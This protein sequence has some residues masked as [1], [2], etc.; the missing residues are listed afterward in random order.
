[1]QKPPPDEYDDT[2]P[3]EAGSE[4]HGEYD[5]QGEL[6]ALAARLKKTNA[7]FRRIEE[8]VEAILSQ[9]SDLSIEIRNVYDPTDGWELKDH[10][11]FLYECYHS[12]VTKFALSKIANVE[13]TTIEEVQSIAEQALSDLGDFEDENPPVHHRLGKGG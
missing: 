3:E 13:A 5:W 10:L 2:R 8:R 6:N 1:M 9:V 11:R 12:R 4:D 7:T